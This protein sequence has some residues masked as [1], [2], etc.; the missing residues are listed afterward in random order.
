[1][2]VGYITFK[3]AL[4][5]K[6]FI[7]IIFNTQSKRFFFFRIRGSKRHYAIWSQVFRESDRF[8]TS[9]GDEN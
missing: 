6:V 3:E 7:Y 9:W 4:L 5:I 1:M 8:K 2:Y